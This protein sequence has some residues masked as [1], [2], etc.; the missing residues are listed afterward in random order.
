MTWEI[1]MFIRRFNISERNDLLQVNEYP[2]KINLSFAVTLGVLFLFLLKRTYGIIFCL[3]AIFD[4]FLDKKLSETLN[5]D[6]FVN[7]IKNNGFKKLEL[8]IVNVPKLS[9]K[10]SWDSFIK[11]PI[12]VFKGQ[13]KSRKFLALI[14]MIMSPVTF[15]F[16]FV[17]SLF[18]L[19]LIYLIS[20]KKNLLILFSKEIYY[21]LTREVPVFK[22]ESEK[23]IF[24]KIKWYGIPGIILIPKKYYKELSHCREVE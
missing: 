24:F 21:K 9:V 4:I 20:R 15:T 17:Y 12:D 6:E 7:L 1:M 13:S 11:A 16:G 23:E 5:Y 14:G 8:S 2:R 19:Y 22:K 3:F 18:E 10:L